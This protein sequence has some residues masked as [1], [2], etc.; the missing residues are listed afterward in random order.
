MYDDAD[1]AMQ[2]LVLDCA[3]CHR[4]KVYPIH[5]DEFLKNWN[6]HGRC[7]LK[8]ILRYKFPDLGLEGYILEAEQ[9]A[10]FFNKI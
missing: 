1:M 5:R 3:S 8:C 2:G 9:S 7:C 10:E 6:K 4:L